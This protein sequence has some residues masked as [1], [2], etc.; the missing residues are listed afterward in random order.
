MARVK[1][2]VASRRRRKRLL[3]QA[4]GYWG[5]RGSHI[6]RAK[7][8]V[9]RAMAYSTRDRKVKKREFRSLWIIRLN[10]AA[11]ERGLTYSRLIAAFK[12]AKIT[13]DRKQLSELAI[14]DPQAFEQVLAA[15]LGSLPSTTPLE[16][17]IVHSP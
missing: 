4:K 12:R 7:E 8:T 17:S 2:Q 3:K 10:A 5:A 16:E 15:A 11:R 9:M 1:W 13:L 6:R 14:N